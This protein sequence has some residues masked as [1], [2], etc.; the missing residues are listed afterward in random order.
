M[1]P[2]AWLS[3]RK[4]PPVREVAAVPGADR[5]C[6]DPDQ[7]R[8]VRRMGALARM[9]LDAQVKSCL[10]TKKCAVLSGGWR[11]EPAD[12]SPEARHLADFAAYALSAADGSITDALYEAMDA[13]ARGVSVAELNWRI[14]PS[15][16]WAGLAALRSIRAKD[17]AAFE[18]KLDRFGNLAGLSLKGDPGGPPLPLEKFAVYIYRPAPGF[19][20]GRSD[21][22][23]AYPHWR[24]R[25][26]LIQYWNLFLEKFGSPT[27][28]G[29]YPGGIPRDRQKQF[30]DLLKSIQQD[31]A[32]VIPEDLE[33]SLMEAQRGGPASYR[34]ALS[35]HDRAIAKAILGE[36]LTNDEG[37]RS[38][39]L[40]LGRVHLE[41][42]HYNV[43]K[44]RRDL[45][46]SLMGEQVVKRLI[47]YNF[48]TD[49]YP[50]FVLAEDSS[51]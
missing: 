3:R 40:A 45:E 39:S 43:R 50:H 18:W 14:V 31:S 15:G 42:L 10:D 5:E 23:S 8:R 17:P 47:A 29:R 6:Y 27:V 36:T 32:L 7:I 20:L 25:E 35:Y 46:E 28:I 44:L 11:V 41:V 21:L 12:G 2:L 33:I 4:T 13:L 24:S 38:G 19:P 51:V 48:A 16:R 30:L 1:N 49:L 34:E 26:L 37:D 9:E 22:L